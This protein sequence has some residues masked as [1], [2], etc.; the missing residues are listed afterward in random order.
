M[1]PKS[2]HS[3][4]PYLRI[5]HSTPTQPANRILAALDAGTLAHIQPKLE[6]ITLE[7]R[8]LLF[9]YDVPIEFVYFPE[10]C[11]GSIVGVLKDGSAVES[12]TVGS[13]GMVGIMLFFGTDRMAAQAFCQVT[14][15]AQRMKATDFRQLLPNPAL[16]AILGKYTQAMLTQIGQSSACN[17]AHGDTQ[18]CAR[19]LLQTHDRV[20]RDEFE[21]MQ[22]FLAQMLGVARPRVSEAAAV[23]AD[24]GSIQY[25][26]DRLNIIDRGALERQSCEC[27]HIIAREYARLIEGIELPSPLIGVPM[28]RDGHSTLTPL[29]AES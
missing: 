10:N 2:T 18:R 28:S 4:R 27:Y 14:G 6:H 19:W 3:N 24:T 8:V 13:E 26:L 21:L 7:R 9:D 23:L 25:R 12:A 11:V 1:R 29:A 15:E 16:H 22:E 5:S 20:H 17:R